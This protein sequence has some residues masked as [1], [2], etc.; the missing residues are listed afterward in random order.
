MAR[1]SSAHDNVDGS[2]VEEDKEDE[3][4]NKRN[5]RVILV[6]SDKLK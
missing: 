5:W 6:I 4:L 2:V 1:A 3:L